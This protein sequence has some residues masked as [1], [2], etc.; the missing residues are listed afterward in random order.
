MAEETEIPSFVEY[1]DDVAN[2][3]APAPLPVGKYHA[4]I[5]EVKPMVSNAKGTKY[6]AVTFLVPPEQ[7]PADY[8]DG[9][10][11]GSKMIYRR[12]SMEANPM[13]MFMMK[14]FLTAIGAPTGRRIEVTDWIGRQATIEIAHTTYEGQ[15]RGEIK[16]VEAA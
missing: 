4:S 10:P 1:A 8:T 16:A 2:A 6:A 15:L 5:V 14:R 13:A 11:D 7:Y 3:K 9:A 12:V